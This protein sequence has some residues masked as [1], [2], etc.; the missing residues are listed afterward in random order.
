MQR[1]VKFPQR[2]D[3]EFLLTHVYISNGNSARVASIEPA[4]LQVEVSNGVMP[5]PR[6]SQVIPES[7]S[8]EVWG[9]AAILQGRSPLLGLEL[10]P[11]HESGGL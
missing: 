5:K 11:I 2:W 10:V 7:W 8:C 1:S 9:K 3:S 6:A 4:S